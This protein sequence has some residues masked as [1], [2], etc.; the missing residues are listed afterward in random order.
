MY[1]K[2]ENHSIFGLSNNSCFGR[3]FFKVSDSRGNREQSPSGDCFCWR[4]GKR[5]DSKGA[6]SDCNKTDDRAIYFRRDVES[7]N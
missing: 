7:I 3:M 1:E 2:E 6:Y 5:G 4:R